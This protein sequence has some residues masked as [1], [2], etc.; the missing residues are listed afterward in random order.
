MAGD[1][2]RSSSFAHGEEPAMR[3]EL[4]HFI[5]R[6]RHF[7]QQALFTEAGEA[8][9]V[10]S[11]GEYH[12]DQGP[13]FKHARIRLG[14]HVYEGSVEIHVLTTD[15]VRHAHDHDR[16]YAQTILHVVWSNDWTAA[17]P[18]ANIPILTLQER[19]PKLMLERYERW[20]KNPVFIP[21]ERQLH[22]VGG[23]AWPPWLETLTRE[24]L[25]RRALA[26]SGALEATRGHWEAVTWMQ[27]ARAVGQPVNAEVFEAIARSLPVERLM[28]LRGEPLRLEA[29]LLGQ[30]G[31]LQGSFSDDYP[32]VLQREY[33]FWQAKWKLEPVTAPLAFLRM[34]PAGFPTIRL[35]QLAGLLTKGG[36][37][38]SRICEAGEPKDIQ[39]LLGVAAG[40]YWE[41][42][43]LFDKG[44]PANVKRLGAAMQLGLFVNAFIP[45]LYAYGWRRKEPACQEKALAWLRGLRAEQNSILA[46][47]KRLGVVAHDAGEGQALLELKK[48]Y[49]A[50]RRC[51]D[52]AIGNRWLMSFVNKG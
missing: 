34:R 2:L 17:T 52:C 26:I 39:G 31:L 45:L 36:G 12:A 4:L 23:A 8:V 30:A 25:Q 43:Y 14:G 19:V 48:E 21:C 18:P 20:M 47:W 44:A 28:R 42:H 29:L 27:M 11:P 1:S 32:L 41:T 37:W 40:G 13:D 9:Q 10:L 7:N 38:F 35:V 15:W 22:E 33:R 3:E 50:E 6:F 5:W 49:C 46:R 16:H 24:R 51:L